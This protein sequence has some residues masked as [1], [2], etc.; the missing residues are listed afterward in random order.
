[1]ENQALFSSKDKSKKLKCRLLQ[2]LFGAIRVNLIL[3]C[4]TMG[5]GVLK[6]VETVIPACHVIKL[7][8]HASMAVQIDG[9]VHYALPVS[10]V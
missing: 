8:E 6:R 2:F 4:A 1:M 9:K 10:L 5:Q 3:Q 7:M